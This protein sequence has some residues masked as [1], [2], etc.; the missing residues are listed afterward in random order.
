M[1]PSVHLQKIFGVCVH[2]KFGGWFA[3]RALLVFEGVTVGAEM[4]QPPPP[5]CVP[6][7]EG[8]IRLL[9]A[10][11]F[12]WQVP[13]HPDVKPVAQ[14]MNTHEGRPNC[15]MLTCGVPH[16]RQVSV[17][18]NSLC[19]IRTGA[20]ETSFNL[21]RPTLRNRGTTFP[22]LLPRGVLCSGPG[23]SYR[24]KMMSPT[25]PRTSAGEWTS[26]SVCSLSQT[27]ATD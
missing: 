22:L 13:Q 9:E 7:R 10:F 15:C 5:D 1:S 17:W 25:P 3:I 8:R 4:E 12:H 11:N 27:P 24:R 2:P 21:P 18:V 14:I 26:C 23:A 6:T 16:C 20:T 19:I